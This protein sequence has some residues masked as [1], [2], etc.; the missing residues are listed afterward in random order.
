[1]PVQSLMPVTPKA[2]S[3]RL[4][5][6]TICQPASRIAST[7]AAFFVAA[8]ASAKARLPERVGW[9]AM[10]MESLMATRLP[11]PPRRNSLMKVLMCPLPR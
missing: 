4:V 7:T 5:L 1:M 9:P 10:S 11:L 3:C 8:G 2:S 6:P